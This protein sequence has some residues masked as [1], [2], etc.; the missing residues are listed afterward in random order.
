MSLEQT[1]RLKKWATFSF[2]QEG[3]VRGGFLWWSLFVGCSLLTLNVE[4][5]S[6][7]LNGALSGTTQ[8]TCSGT[9]Y[10]SGGSGGGYSS[11]QNFTVT[12]CSSNGANLQLAFNSFNVELSYDFL[13]I[14]NGSSTSAPQVVGSPFTG[15]NSPGTVTSGGTCLTVKFTSDNVNT[16]PGWQAS[17]NCVSTA[18]NCTCANNL[19]LNSTFES[20]NTTNWTL[21]GAASVSYPTTYDLCGSKSVAVSTTNGTLVDPGLWQ[22]VGSVTE[23]AVY[24]LNF[25]GGTKQPTYL[26][27]AYLLFYNSSNTLLSQNYLD[28][29]HNLNINNKLQSYSFSMV[30]P[31]GATT[32]RVAF[33]LDGDAFYLDNICLVKSSCSA[34]TFTFLNP[35]HLSGTY[36][37]AGST[38]RFANVLPGTDAI[39]TIQS[40][41][42]SDVMVE[43]IDEPAATNGGYDWAF[44]P[45][46]D[47]N[48]FNDPGLDPA[49]NKSV[50][51][52]FD[53]VDATTNAP[54]LVPIMN[55]TAVDV[56]G[57]DYEVREF[58]Q[59]SGFQSY[60][61]QSPTQ[62][63]LSG[64]LKALG[65]L[66]A[67]N[68]VVETALQTMISYVYQNLSSITVTYGANYNGGSYLDDIVESRLN[69]LY[70]KCYD[71]NTPVVCP[72]VSISGGV[73]TCSGGSVTLNASSGS[74]SGTCNLQWQ[75]STDNVSWAD[76]S[77]AT[78][79]SYT[80]PAL[81]AT[82]Y[83]R[84]TYYCTG[85]TDCGTIISNVETVNIV[86]APS[87]PDVVIFNAQCGQSDG[88]LTINNVSNVYSN[89][90]GGP[91]NWQKANYTNLTPVNSTFIV[92]I[93]IIET[94]ESP[95]I[96]NHNSQTDAYN[97]N[98]HP[99]HTS[100]KKPQQRR[101][102][103]QK[104]HQ[105]HVFLPV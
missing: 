1:L 2:N 74:A 6:Y 60:E 24:T 91:W 63:T 102:C 7:S 75:V 58:I 97:Q 79:N 44:Q 36:G 3:L 21:G 23:G 39:L 73:N 69:C 59:A 100:K 57:D 83:Y 86:A 13:Y 82:R 34:P 25:D 80:T 11:S 67:Y 47:Y 31:A 9:F 61:T 89:L 81:T 95:K 17:V 27:R 53:F 84:A 65:P 51:F 46:I 40:T 20:G 30:A 15:T 43:S 55:M 103:K 14:Y 16:A 101:C 22:Q 78:A 41:T 45:I 50:N 32:V 18:N 72:T 88:S 35:T 42:H 12:F 64:S 29:N 99:K 105:H 93:K 26:H 87:S 85:S 33:A 62:L 76:I 48:W 49:G 92:H 8:T 68:G 71:F 5:Q 94:P 19:L 37:M 10:D 28:V 4:G 90:D 98:F 52:K 56:D 54:K 38:Y 70:F 104:G 66:Q 96:T 77:G